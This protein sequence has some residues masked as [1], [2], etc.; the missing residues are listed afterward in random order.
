[1]VNRLIHHKY[2]PFSPRKP[3]LTSCNNRHGFVWMHMYKE[4]HKYHIYICTLAS[5]FFFATQEGYRWNMLNRVR[6]T[7]TYI[8]EICWTRFT[9]DIHIWKTHIVINV[10]SEMCSCIHPY[11]STASSCPVFLESVPVLLQENSNVQQI[12]L[13]CTLG[14]RSAVGANCYC[15]YFA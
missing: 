12:S 4:K 8:S 3:N 13:E 11:H 1:M 5:Q 10:K 9:T 2:N 6:N 15:F 14:H 7:H